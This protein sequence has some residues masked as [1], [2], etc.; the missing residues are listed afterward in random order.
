MVETKK[1]GYSVSIICHCQISI[2]KQCYDA[3]K[4]FNVC[5]IPLIYCSKV[6]C[7]CYNIM[8]IK[9]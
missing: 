3:L 8:K 4:A 7:E 5:N 1:N 6:F 2:R 9:R